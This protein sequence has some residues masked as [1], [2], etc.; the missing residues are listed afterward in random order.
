[1]VEGGIKKKA[2]ATFRLLLLHHHLE[3]KFLLLLESMKLFS[4][5]PY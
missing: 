4:M 2:E 1:L 5:L 3:S